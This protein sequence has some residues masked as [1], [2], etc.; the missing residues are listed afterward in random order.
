M[1]ALMKKA[2]YHNDMDAVT[3]HPRNATSP[4]VFSEVLNPPERYVPR[5]MC[6]KCFV[7]AAPPPTVQFFLIVFLEYTIFQV[8]REG[9]N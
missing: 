3:K 7:P 9:R 5:T 4:Y 1:E 6:P 2:Q 8:V